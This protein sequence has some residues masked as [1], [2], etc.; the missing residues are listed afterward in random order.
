MKPG[1]RKVGKPCHSSFGDLPPD[2]CASVG[3]VLAR[4]GDKWSILV[5]AMLSRGSMRFSELKRSIG[6][7]SQKVLTTTVR[8]SSGT[9]TSPAR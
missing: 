6:S 4:V 1:H 5:I 3:D 9:D 2:I 7:I 8:V